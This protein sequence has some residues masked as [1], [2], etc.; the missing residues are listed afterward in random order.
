[1]TQVAY[2]IRVSGLVQGVGFRWATKMVADQ[3]GVH[4]TVANMADGSVEIHV[5][6]DEDTMAKFKAA[7]KKG[8]SP[9][10]RVSTYEEERI[11]PLPNYDRFTV[12]A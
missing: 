7:V 2:K 12:I 5:Q 8:P 9:Y 1:M 10:S 4:G 6:T 11:L 3:L